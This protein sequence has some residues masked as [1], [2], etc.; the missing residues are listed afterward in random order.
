M[1]NGAVSD[2]ANVRPF[3]HDIRFTE[4]DGEIR[5]GIL[6][7]IVRLA[8]EMF[9]LEEK[10]GIV[11]ANRGAQQAANVER[12]GRHYHAQA[13]N[14]REHHFAALAVINRPT[15]EVAADGNAYDDRSFEMYR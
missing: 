9:V 7:A 4:W 8:I 10:H 1:H 11:G 12:C 5:A 14:V 13:G 2:D 3:A 15:R 6:R